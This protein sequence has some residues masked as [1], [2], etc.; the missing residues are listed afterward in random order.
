MEIIKEHIDHGKGFDWGRASEDYAKF[1]DVYPPVFYDKLIGIGLCT[2]GQR[3]LDVGTGTGVIPRNMYKYGAVFTGADISENQIAHARR[4]SREAGMDISYLVSPAEELDFPDNSFDVITACQC[5]IYFDKQVI[6]PKFHKLLKSGGQF[7]KLSMIWLIEESPIAA[8][9]EKIVLKHNPSW[10]DHSLKRY[11]EDLEAEAGGL[12]EAAHSLAYDVAVSF[13]RESWHG[14]IKACRGIG[15]SSLNSE[16]LAA[17]E[18][19]HLE[20]MQTVPPT[21]DIPHYATVFS[22]RKI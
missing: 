10:T 11:T 16:Q 5:Y 13:T 12:F 6:Y 9:S 4:L 19:E 14:R 3:V 20:F 18:R 8:Q 2:S 21:F 7:C 1:R 15:A 17:F 22:L